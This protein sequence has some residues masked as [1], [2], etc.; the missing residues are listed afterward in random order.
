MKKITATTK[1]T[2]RKFF[3]SLLCAA[4]IVSAGSISLAV[5]ETASVLSLTVSAT[6]DRSSSFNKNYKL[7]RKPSFRS[8]YY[9]LYVDG[10]QKHVFIDDLNSAIKEFEKWAH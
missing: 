10:T 5:P 1:N 2:K 3:A 7:T 9:T 8:D 6:Q 4:T